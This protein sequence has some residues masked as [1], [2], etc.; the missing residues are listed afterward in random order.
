MPIIRKDINEDFAHEGG[1][2]GLKV[3]IDGIAYI[4]K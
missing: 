2:K 1:D 4:G 3:Q